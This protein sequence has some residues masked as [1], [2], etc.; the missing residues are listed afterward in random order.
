ME[1]NQ[2]SLDPHL[3]MITNYDLYSLAQWLLSRNLIKRSSERRLSAWDR[4]RRNNYENA[5]R[6]EEA[7]DYIGEE[8][9]GVNGQNAVFDNAKKYG[10]DW[11]RSVSE[12]IVDSGPNLKTPD[13]TLS[14]SQQNA[15]WK[16]DKSPQ[17]GSVMINNLDI[18]DDY[19]PYSPN[20][21]PHNSQPRKNSYSERVDP[22]GTGSSRTSTPKMPFSTQRDKFL[23]PRG[24]TD[25]FDSSNN[26]IKRESKYSAE[27]D[28]GSERW[29]SSRSIEPT[30]D[31]Q[32]RSKRVDDQFF[33]NQFGRDRNPLRPGMGNRIDT[34]RRQ[35][36][37]DTERG[38]IDQRRA[39]NADERA[40]F[41]DLISRP[42]N[43]LG[44]SGLDS[45]RMMPGVNE[46]GA[47]R[48]SL[49]RFEDRNGPTFGRSRQDP[50]EDGRSLRDRDPR[51]R[52]EMDGL[53]SFEDGISLISDRITGGSE[54]DQ[55]RGIFGGLPEIGRREGRYG[56]GEE[57]GGREGG[58]G[59]RERYGY[60]AEIGSERGI[61]QGSFDG[62]Y[63]DPISRS[64]GYSSGYGPSWGDLSSP[65]SAPNSEMGGRGGWQE[66][67]EQPPLGVGGGSWW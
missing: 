32:D 18:D 65:F 1:E 59:E 21:I 22:F 20:L 31:A 33:D 27:T 24:R 48:S 62:G 53:P 63:G 13:P 56:G 28:H 54:F 61:Y 51:N 58:F 29:G 15:N 6:N 16:S 23:A 11:M 49:P 41:I 38:R 30:R 35:P 36:G 60:P 43:N 26:Q 25:E 46:Y 2:K 44:T 52:G 64:D 55:G 8:N 37:M 50:Y 14:P 7:E 42:L 39:P 66:R 4:P 47:E 67:F 17:Q 57:F 40:G 12:R 5:Y 3:A 19:D 10:A 9:K 34:N 45:G